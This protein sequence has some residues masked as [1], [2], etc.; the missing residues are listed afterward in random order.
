MLRKISNRSVK[1]SQ[2]I[3]VAIVASKYNSELTDELL[4]HCLKTL[5][6]QG[7]LDVQTIRVPGCYEIPVMVAR[8]ARSKNPH[9]IIALGVV[10]QGRTSHAEH[11][12][13]AS[14]IHLQQIAV[15]TGVPVIHQILSP[16]NLRDAQA[17]VRLRGIEAAQ[18]AI[19]M[20]VLTKGGR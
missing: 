3:R 11:I 6:Q 10:I 9:A 14:S 17:R 1:V 19:E 2:R 7:V 15:D 18:T 16:R 12:T 4:A 13:L 5:S 8:L 20:A